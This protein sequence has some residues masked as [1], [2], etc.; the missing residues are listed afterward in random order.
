MVNTSYSEAC[1]FCHAPEID[2]ASAGLVYAC[3]A[4]SDGPAPV[5]TS[6]TMVCRYLSRSTA[7]IVS[8]N[9]TKTVRTTLTLD[10]V[11]RARLDV[12]ALGEVL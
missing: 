7:D 9:G 4:R 10:E 8:A 11:T 1:P 6:R 2:E 12:R 3:G 5:D